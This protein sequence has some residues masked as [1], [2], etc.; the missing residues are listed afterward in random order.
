MANRHPLD[1]PGQPLASTKVAG[2]VQFDS[3]DFSVVNGVVSLGG[4][5]TL[6][7]ALSGT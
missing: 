4:T 2:P 5:E 3:T 7:V 1:N 6:A